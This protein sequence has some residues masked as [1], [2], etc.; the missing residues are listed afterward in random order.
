MS[1]STAGGNSLIL[2]RQPYELKKHPVEGFSAGKH[3]MLYGSA[4]I[5]KRDLTYVVYAGLVDDNNLL[6]WEVMII[7]CVSPIPCGLNIAS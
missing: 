3:M 2:R 1:R 7:G 5:F 6:E 4:F